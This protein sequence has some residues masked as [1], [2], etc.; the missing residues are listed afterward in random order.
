MKRE[1]LAGLHLVRGLCALLV[2]LYHYLHITKVGTFHAMGTYAVYIFFA[3]SGYT[4]YYVYG[5]EPLTEAGLRKFFLA[6]IF[7]IAPLYWLVIAYQMLV[8]AWTPVRQAEYALNLTGLF[9]LATPG[10][11]S[12]T[13][14]GW[15]IGIEVVF[16]LLFPALV[17]LRSTRS[18]AVVFV[19]SLVVNALFVH[20][21]FADKALAANNWASYTQPAT[22]L[23]YFVGGM[24]AAKVTLERGW[25]AS[26]ANRPWAILAALALIGL[27][28]AVPIALGYDRQQTLDGLL[29]K[30]LVLASI[31]VVALAALSRLDGLPERIGTFLGNISYATY[32]FHLIVW[33]QVAALLPDAS[34]GVKAALSAS[35]TIGLAWLSQRYFEGW[36]RRLQYRF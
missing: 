16:Y 10:E 19:V 3:L 23:C 6:R 25:L 14:A 20:A 28:C 21:T 4:L 18:L 29:P 1:T 11:T 36:A 13:P 35:I 33:G 30:A 34:P 15:S 12:A 26:S 9:G 2:M 31:L 8:G 22:F 32:L 7:R 17:L 5:E 27:I 24:L